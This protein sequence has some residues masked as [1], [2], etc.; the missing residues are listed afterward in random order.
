MRSPGVEF[1]VDGI[2][3]FGILRSLPVSMA[4]SRLG[5]SEEGMIGT[6]L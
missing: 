3:A 6:T 1:L 4:C 5:R 2:Q